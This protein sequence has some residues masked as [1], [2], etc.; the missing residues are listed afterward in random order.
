MKENNSLLWQGIVDLQIM[1]IL[2]KANLKSRVSDRIWWT[3]AGSLRSQPPRNT[4]IRPLLDNAAN[5]A[6][7]GKCIFVIGMLLLDCPITT[8][9]GTH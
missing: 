6:S 7:P 5:V 1:D 9:N 3:D 4:H 2:Q 8:A